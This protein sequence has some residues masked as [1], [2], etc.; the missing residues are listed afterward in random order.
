MW[1]LLQVL[2]AS[3]LRSTAAIRAQARHCQPKSSVDG[4]ASTTVCYMPYRRHD[5]RD[6]R[7]CHITT[8]AHLN[9][10]TKQS[11]TIHLRYRITVAP[12][13]QSACSCT[14]CRRQTTELKLAMTLQHLPPSMHRCTPSVVNQHIWR[15]HRGLELFWWSSAAG[16]KWCSVTQSSNTLRDIVT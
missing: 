2:V 6:S 5:D 14:V 8:V 11:V 9:A 7:G 16:T 3:R 12:T 4:G 10:D 1:R 13:G 15:V